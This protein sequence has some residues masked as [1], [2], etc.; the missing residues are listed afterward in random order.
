MTPL[1]LARAIGGLAVGGEWH[2]PHLLKDLSKTEK[3]HVLKVN[4][5][6][7][8]TLVD[9]MHAVVQSGTGVRARLPNVE[10][11]GKTGTAQLA[12]NQYLSGKGSVR[13]LLDNAWF[14]GFAPRQ[15]PEI[16]VVALWENGEHGNLAAPIVR[17]VLKAYFD[18]KARLAGRSYGAHTAP[19]DAVEMQ[20]PAVEEELETAPQAPAE[21][22]DP[23]PE[24]PSQ[25]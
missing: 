25:P 8:R 14:V 9:G 1:Q 10:V 24:V 20:S 2:H 4:P 21:G 18:K 22:P 12:S 3:P 6:N 7:V 5:D 23:Q 13:H 17:D 19:P 11:C 15:A 16:V